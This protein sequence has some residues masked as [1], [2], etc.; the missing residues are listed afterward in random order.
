M[1]FY[2][3]PSSPYISFT[4]HSHRHCLSFKSLW[5]VA[6]PD[7]SLAWEAGTITEGVCMHVIQRIKS[8]EWDK[9]GVVDCEGNDRMS[10]GMDN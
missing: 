4:L 3:P 2:H 5:F 8:F 6:A 1:P 7:S 10:R 9:E